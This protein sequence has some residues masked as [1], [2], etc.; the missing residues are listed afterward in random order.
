MKQQLILTAA[1][2]LATATLASAANIVWNDDGVDDLYTNADN[3]QTPGG[4]TTAA[5]GPSD[6]AFFRDDA[7]GGTVTLNTAVTNI[8]IQYQDRTSPNGPA[9]SYVIG[10][11]GSL[12]LTAPAS[13]TGSNEFAIFV[14]TAATQTI[15][16]PVFASQGG[17]IRVALGQLV[18]GDLRLAGGSLLERSEIWAN[19]TT[20]INGAL[21]IDGPSQLEMFPS[22]NRT[23]SIGDSSGETWDSDL[24]ILNWS[25]DLDDILVSEG[26]FTPAQLSAITFDG[27][28]PG[29]GILNGELVPLSVVPEPAS[30]VSLLGGLGLLAAR[31]RR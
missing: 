10:G 22:G 15:E 18:L 3:W 29:A 26:S 8:R 16:V 6:A 12:E 27:F 25:N 7:T 13:A 11:T 1:A 30:A 24:L 28:D 21:D 31:R 2:T 23:V 14:S 9:P 20:T 17:D 19:Q 5:P 4:G